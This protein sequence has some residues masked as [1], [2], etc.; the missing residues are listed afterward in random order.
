M[1]GQTSPV[2]RTYP[3]SW[4]VRHLQSTEHIPGHE[5]SDISSPQNISL[6][7]RGQTSP[8]HR[9]YP[10][11]WEA[12]H[13]QSV[14]WRCL[15]SH[16]QGY[17]VCCDHN[18]V[19]SSYMTCQRICNKGDMKGATN[20]VATEIIK[21]IVW[22]GKSK[23]IWGTQSNE[24]LKCLWK[25][26]LNFNKVVS[27]HVNSDHIC[28]K[29]F[30]AETNTSLKLNLFSFFICGCQHHQRKTICLYVYISNIRQ[31]VGYWTVNTSIY[32][33]V[34]LAFPYYNYFYGYLL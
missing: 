1:R 29:D 3:W 33:A 18:L 25:F 28:I 17:A 30:N 5:R 6:V 34:S 22:Y 31:I 13:L 19:L 2:H 24:I 16:D 10:W 21:S 20:G 4:E 27:N 26:L 11:S 15:T 7:M 12:R 8:V 23:N 14:D 32:S 9:T